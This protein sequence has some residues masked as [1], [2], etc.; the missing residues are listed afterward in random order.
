MC[1]PLES[2]LC[3]SSSSMHYNNTHHVLGLL[4]SEG[5]QHELFLR[6]TVP[7][8]FMCPG[9]VPHLKEFTD[10]TVMLLDSQFS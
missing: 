6:N 10:N 4:L 5:K 7:F 1:I 3:C 2:K 8:H 9:F